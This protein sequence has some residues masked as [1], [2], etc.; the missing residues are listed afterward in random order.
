MF[1]KFPFFYIITLLC[2]QFMKVDTQVISP[3]YRNLHSTIL[4]G[5]K[6]YISGGITE[7]DDPKNENKSPDDTFFFLDV[8]KPFDTSKLPWKTI[9]NNIEN[10]PIESLSSVFTGGMAVGIGGVNNDTTF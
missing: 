10:L 8:S 7:F 9:P 4:I 6:L 5:D 1:F 3:S 2:F